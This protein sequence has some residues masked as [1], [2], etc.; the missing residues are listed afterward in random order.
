MDSFYFWLAGGAVVTTL[1]LKAET[2]EGGRQVERARA[3]KASLS[4]AEFA[5]KYPSST[6]TEDDYDSPERDYHGP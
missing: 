3:D 5:K 4:P 6:Q 2:R 1:C